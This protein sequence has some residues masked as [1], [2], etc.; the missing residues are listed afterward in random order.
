MVA[1]HGKGTL[2]RPSQ[3]INIAS[4]IPIRVRTCQS[5]ADLT[6]NFI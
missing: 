3:Y 4:A 2:K 6:S 5:T 1:D